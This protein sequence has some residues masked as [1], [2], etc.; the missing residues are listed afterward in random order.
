MTDFG[1]VTVTAECP[2]DGCDGEDDV[3]VFG[4]DGDT[5]YRNVKCS[6]CSV[7]YTVAIAITCEGA[8]TEY[9]ID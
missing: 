5:I 4:Q 3:R 8:A 1:W 9:K 6:T 2:A 7:T